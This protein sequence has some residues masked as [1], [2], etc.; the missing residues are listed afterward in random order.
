MSDSQEKHRGQQRGQ[1]PRDD[2]AMLDELVY[3]FDSTQ[4]IQTLCHTY[5]IDFI[6]FSIRESV[7]IA[8]MDGYT[9]ERKYTH[10]PAPRFQISADIEEDP[11]DTMQGLR[12]QLERFLTYIVDVEFL[13]K[14]GALDLTSLHQLDSAGK[15]CYFVENKYKGERTLLYDY[16]DRKYP[17]FTKRKYGDA[18][19]AERSQALERWIVQRGELREKLLGE[20]IVAFW[21][22]KD[23]VHIIT[24][25]AKG[26]EECSNQELQL[27]VLREEI[28]RILTNHGMQEHMTM[29]ETDDDERMGNE[30]EDGYGNDDEEKRIVATQSF[31]GQTPTL[32]TDCNGRLLSDDEAEILIEG[33]KKELEEY[34]PLAILIEESDEKHEEHDEETPWDRSADELTDELTWE[35]RRFER[36]PGV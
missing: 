4:S 26:E 28:A 29:L 35:V 17:P 31:G 22:E 1:V 34:G 12:D 23:K 30:L 9:T 7:L 11:D 8:V 27:I 14:D 15:V 19:V 2:E 25:I 24:E 5:G 10:T 33:L 36:L 13:T 21:W 20:S 3:C 6:T 18:T 16:H 32:T